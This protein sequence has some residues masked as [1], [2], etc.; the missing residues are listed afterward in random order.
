M[1]LRK[2]GKHFYGDSQADIRPE[3]GRYSRGDAYVVH[4][5][6][7]E[8]CTCGATA[9]CLRVDDEE[10]A[11]LVTCP[12]CNVERALADSARYLDVAEL[13]ECECPCGNDALEITLGV[14]LYAGSEDV[15]WLYIGCR[16]PKCKLVATYADSMVDGSK[17]ASRG[18]C[19]SG[20]RSTPGMVSSW[21][22]QSARL[23]VKMCA[24]GLVA[25]GVSRLPA[26][27]TTSRPPICTRGNAEPHVA[28]KVFMWRVPGSVKLVTRSSPASHSS[29]ASDENR[30]A[31]CAEPVPLRQCMQ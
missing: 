4:R 27:S 25:S 11:A 8:A 30:F 31:P 21:W 29:R 10:G 16:C 28:Q 5:F 24:L 9:L 14:S 12:Q 19:Y 17:R 22:S 18:T 6:K 3:L 13:E 26:G 1:G 20:S 15:R 2:R 7:D 23:A